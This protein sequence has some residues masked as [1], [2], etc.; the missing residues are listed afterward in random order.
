MVVLVSFLP[1]LFPFLRLL[2]FYLFI[3]VCFSQ[4]VVFL[5]FYICCFPQVV[6]MAPKITEGPEP[7]IVIGQ[8]KREKDDENA[9]M[10]HESR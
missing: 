5:L 9:I 1:F 4:V 6:V 7:V 10:T 8:R 3:F 2:F